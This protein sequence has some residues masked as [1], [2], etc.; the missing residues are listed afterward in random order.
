M[1]LA[2]AARA[3]GGRAGGGRLVLQTRQP[4]HPVVRAVVLAD[5]GRFVEAE[6]ARR[7]ALRYPPSGA[8]AV[9][10]GAAA[11]AWAAAAQAVAGLGVEVLGPSDSRWLVR[12]PS[13]PELADFLASVERP[14]GRL[15]IEV[16]PARA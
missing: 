12:A 8:L 11:P 4:E 13:W 15:R 9:V 3:V 1:L 16:D 10:S 5:P 2:R 14:P 7:A 6:S